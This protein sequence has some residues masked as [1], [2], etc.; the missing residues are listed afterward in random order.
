MDP[1]F[2]IVPCFIVL[3]IGIILFAAWSNKKRTEAWR[4]VADELGIE[5]LGDDNDVLARCGAMKTF[6]VGRSRHASNA[7]AGDAGDT[8]ITICDY[9]YTTGSGK[10]RHI[11][12]RTVCI[13]QSDKLDVPH[14]YL[15]PEAL[16]DSLG[17]LFGGQDID[18][19][20]DPDFS[21]AFVL[22]G[23]DEAAVRALFDADVRAW[24][25]ERRKQGFYFE[26]QGNL[27]V[28]HTGG[29]RK[30]SEAKDLMQQALEI[31]TRLSRE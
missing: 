28:F 15:R 6:S 7:I 16:F 20:D 4:Q 11:R 2:Y 23:D 19:V 22:Q 27:L 30:P 10:N 13:L 9:R 24:F 5:F 31:M 21:K 29:R 3:T 26:G 8:Q 14:C 17:A 12:Q 1:I 25:T 18:F